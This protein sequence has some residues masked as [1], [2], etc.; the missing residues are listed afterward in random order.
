MQVEGGS[1]SGDGYF[2]VDRNPR[3]GKHGSKTLAW[4]D[5]LIGR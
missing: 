4:A 3:V 1:A 5:I 2:R